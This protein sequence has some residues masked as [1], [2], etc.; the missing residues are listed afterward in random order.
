LK[1]FAVA[2]LDLCQP[3]AIRAL[4]KSGWQV[5]AHPRR[6]RTERRVI[7]IDL[8]AERGGRRIYVE[9]KCFADVTYADEQYRAIG[10]YLV[11][12]AVL[13]IVHDDTPLYL[14]IPVTMYEKMDTVLCHLIEEY[15]I[16]YVLFD[17]VQD[18]IRSWNE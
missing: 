7:L 8:V 11:Y 3:S 16:K 13:S 6:L 5:D 1:G 2:A 18:T 12:R 10:Q 17:E 15:K 14:T 4:T 9:V